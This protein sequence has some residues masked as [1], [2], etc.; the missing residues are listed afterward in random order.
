MSTNIHTINNTT[1]TRYYAGPEGVKYQLT[2]RINGQ[3][4]Y[5]QLTKAELENILKIIQ[6]S[7]DKN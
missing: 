6:K 3:F 4:N 2:Q 1:I 5:V 7:V